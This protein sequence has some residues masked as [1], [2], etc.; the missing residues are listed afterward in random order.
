M[1]TMHLWSLEEEPDPARRPDT[2][3]VEEFAQRRE[4]CVERPGLQR[5]TQEGVDDELPR[6]ELSTI[7]PGCL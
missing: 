3:V 6:I 1:N 7:S 5:E 4:Q 2:G